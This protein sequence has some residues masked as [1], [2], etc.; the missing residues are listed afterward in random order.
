VPQFPLHLLRFLLHADPSQLADEL[1][2]FA[3]WPSMISFDG[4]PSTLQ[5]GVHE[6]PP[7]IEV[8]NPSGQFTARADS[9]A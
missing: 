4:N 1:D 7:C 6:I 5:I 9:S 3:G 2:N 8:T